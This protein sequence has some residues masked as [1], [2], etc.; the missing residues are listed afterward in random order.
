METHTSP[1][2]DSVAAAQ[3]ASEWARCRPWIQAALEKAAGL[4]T[5][6]NVERL[7]AERIYVFVEM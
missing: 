5:V 3:R 7:I 1:V 4:Q 2:E 6:E